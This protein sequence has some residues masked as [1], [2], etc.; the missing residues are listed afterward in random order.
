MNG[1]ARFCKLLKLNNKKLIAKLAFN[2]LVDGSNPSRPTKLK[3]GLPQG[4]PFLVWT[5]GGEPVRQIDRRPIWVTLVGPRPS[6]R[7]GASQSARPT[8]F[9]SKISY[10]EGFRKGAFFVFYA[11]DWFLLP[12]F[13]LALMTIRGV[14]TVSRI[15]PSVQSVWRKCGNDSCRNQLATR[16]KYIPQ[17][18]DLPR[19][20][21]C[22][23]VS[24]CPELTIT[25]SSLLSS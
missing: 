10:L 23:S 15:R 3:K 24:E 13:L 14:V 19:I 8:I 25:S 18:Q 12:F 11:I 4:G 21:A 9:K 16:H 7:D 5:D 2:Q 1:L 17:G 6:A 22:T 20:I